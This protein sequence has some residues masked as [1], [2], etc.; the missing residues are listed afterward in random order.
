MAITVGAGLL[1]TAGA[2]GVT[3]GLE[4]DHVC[5]ITGLTRGR[6]GPKPSAVIGGCFALGHALVVLLWIV[7]AY[8]ILGVTSFPR[9][10]EQI[11][12]VIVGIVL[13]VIGLSLGSS[14]VTDL[15][16]TAHPR[17]ERGSDAPSDGQSHLQSS[18]R[19]EHRVS[20]A[21]RAEFGILEYCKIGT[22]GTLFT[23]SPPISMI[24]FVSI[25]INE[26]G[27]M[28]ILALVAAYAVAITV[29]MAA[30]GGGSGAV[31]RFSEARNK[32]FHAIS[33]VIAAGLIM[34]FAATWL[35]RVV[36]PL[37]VP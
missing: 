7:V 11:G 9:S 29:T 16:A 26:R 32:R 6:N 24:A 31:F 34:V 20:A 13:T 2:L 14:G 19:F 30:V 5:G 36:S 18:D 35:G 33:R 3:H 1:V 25:T 17:A 12:G 15:L 22:V 10:F 21:K 23:L 27:L 4:P 28:A 8:W 37:P